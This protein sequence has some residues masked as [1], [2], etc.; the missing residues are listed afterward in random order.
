M[1]KTITP[2]TPFSL[3]KAAEAYLKSGIDRRSFLKLCAAA[4][5]GFTSPSFLTGCSESPSNKPA[6]KS[7]DTL[8]PQSASLAGTDQHK[9]LAEMGR[10]FAGTTL[11]VVTEDTPPCKRDQK[12]FGG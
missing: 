11:R 6:E 2:S 5:F 9:F 12:A 3:A 10:R 8:G 7:A 1:K 4:G